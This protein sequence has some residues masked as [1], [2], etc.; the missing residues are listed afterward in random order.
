ML[1]PHQL[2]IF[3]VAAE[4]LNFSS[5][6]AKLNLSQPGVTQHI[7]ALESQL[8]APLFLR[9]G[10]KIRLTATGEALLPM[11]RQLISLNLR[12]EELMDGLRS[13]ILG[14][15][16]I[17]CSTT[18]G[19]YLLPIVL[20][21]FMRL[22]PRVQATCQ[23]TSRTQALAMLECGE[24][25]FAF[26]SS[27]EEF[28]RNFEFSRFLTDPIL[29]IAPLDHEWAVRREI[30]FADL[31]QGRFIMREPSAGTYRVTRTGLATC[32]LNISDLQVVFSV[33]SSEAVAI[34]VQQGLGVGFVSRT[35]HENLSVGK[36]AEI[37]IHGLDLVQEIFFCRHRLQSTG[38]V[39]NAFWNYIQ[40]ISPIEH[41]QDLIPSAP[42]LAAPITV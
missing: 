26:S 32:G 13:Q 19:K 28:D 11:A 20:S 40:S 1:D 35:L 14:H 24:V 33:G 6:A 5:A 27:S 39:Q 18:P 15:L 7:K 23:V 42:V 2:Q 36:V 8:D 30:E 4:T 3:V 29:L 22:Y 25:H 21:N 38:R 16:I 10:R 9:T 37:R 34:A 41:P 12:A 17:G 31:P